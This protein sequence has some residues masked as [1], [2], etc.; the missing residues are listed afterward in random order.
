MVFSFACAGHPLPLYRATREPWGNVQAVVS[1]PLGTRNTSQQPTPCKTNMFKTILSLFP[2]RFLM[3]LHC[4][5]AGNPLPLYR[6]SHEPWGKVQAVIS[7]PLGT[8]SNSHEPTPCRTNIRSNS[9]KPTPCRTNRLKRMLSRFPVST[10]FSY[11]FQLCMCWTPAPA[12]P[13]HP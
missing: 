10:A 11:G 13:C 2:A 8:L 3:V 7:R 4:T 12:V 5:C 6:T 1:C 9:N